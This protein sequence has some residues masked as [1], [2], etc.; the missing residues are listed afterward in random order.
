MKTHV[1]SSQTY[2]CDVGGTYFDRE[3]ARNRYIWKP[4]LIPH[5]AIPVGYAQRVQPS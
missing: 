5:R 4:M 1:D 3:D 2:T